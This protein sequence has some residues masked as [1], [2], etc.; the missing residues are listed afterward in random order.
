MPPENKVGS[1]Q[2]QNTSARSK[3]ECARV[4]PVCNV[5][6]AMLARSHPCCLG[7][8]ALWPRIWGPKWVLKLGSA[9][10][11]KS[12]SQN[13]T[14][15]EGTY[16]GFLRSWCQKLPRIMGPDLGPTCMR[17]LTHGMH[18]QFHTPLLRS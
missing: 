18:C 13:G 14:N 3:M 17:F 12:W 11:P 1:K 10:E 15:I 16:S 4:Q 7:Q 9:F 5:M 2:V 6:L 8:R